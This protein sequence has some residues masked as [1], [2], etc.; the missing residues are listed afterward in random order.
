MDFELPWPSLAMYSV[1]FHF[2]LHSGTW[3]VLHVASLT[4][5]ATPVQS[6]SVPIPWQ[7]SHCTFRMSF[8]VPV[9]PNPPAAPCPVTWQGRQLSS[10]AFPCFSRVANAW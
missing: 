8:V 7:D 6:C 1:K 5:V 2:G 3:H 4:G 10:L 9:T